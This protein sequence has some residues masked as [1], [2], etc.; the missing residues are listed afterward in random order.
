MASNKARNGRTPETPG[1]TESGRIIGLSG[2]AQ[3]G[4]DTSASFLIEDGYT[5]L[6][7]A[8]VL[9]DSV[10]RLNPIIHQNIDSSVV[11]V[12][13]LVDA[14]G[15]DYVKV[16][17]PEIRGLLQRMGT[18]VGRVLFGENVWVDLAMKGIE[19]G[20]NYVITDVR[21][22]NEFEAIKTAGGQVWRITRQGTGPVN[23]HPSE[24]ALDGFEFDRVI[25]NDGTLDELGEAVRDV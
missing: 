20:K 3:S 14:F 24:T 21:F 19:E 9:R 13:D 2:Y 11:R 18:D 22:P 25:E 4:K 7:F 15:W 10:Y 5:R 23:G 8:D 16:N 1:R 17:Y 6:A 12:K